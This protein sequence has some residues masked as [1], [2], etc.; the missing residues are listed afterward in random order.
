MASRTNSMSGDLE[1]PEPRANGYRADENTVCSSVL[2]ANSP[3]YVPINTRNPNYQVHAQALN[4]YPNGSYQQQYD[5][6]YQDQYHEHANQDTVTNGGSYGTYDPS[7]M[8]YVANMPPYYHYPSPALLQ[9]QYFH[10]PDLYAQQHPEGGAR[11]EGHAGLVDSSSTN[12][13]VG[14]ATTSTSTSL[15]LP[16][17]SASAAAPSPLLSTPPISS[18]SDTS[19]IHQ[20]PLPRYPHQ[21]MLNRTSFVPNNLLGPNN[22]H[23]E[24]PQVQTN[25]NPGANAMVHVNN[26]FVNLSLFNS[27]G[28][29]TGVAQASPLANPG[30]MMQ[31]PGMSLHHAVPMPGSNYPFGMSYVQP[32]HEPHYPSPGAH[33]RQPHGAKA[34]RDAALSATRAMTRGR[35]L[36]SHRGETGAQRLPR[37]SEGDRS[38]IGSGVDRNSI[39]EEMCDFNESDFSSNAPGNDRDVH[40]ARR[41][42]TDSQNINNAS[43]N[44]F[45]GAPIFMTP[46]IPYQPRNDGYVY[47]NML[48]FN[49]VAIAP[50]VP[51]GI[52]NVPQV[53]DTAR[54]SG[55]SSPC[56]TT[57]IAGVTAP[58]I[59]NVPSNYISENNMSRTQN[60]MPIPAHGTMLPNV[61]MT[62]HLDV[63]NTGTSASYTDHMTAFVT[64]PQSCVPSDHHDNAYTTVSSNSVNTGMIYQSNNSS[65][66]HN[67]SQEEVSVDNMTASSLASPVCSVNFTSATSDTLELSSNT[68]SYVVTTAGD[69]QNEA[70]PVYAAYVTSSHQSIHAP[71]M[72]ELAHEYANIEVDTSQAGNDAA[73]LIGGDFITAQTSE[74]PNGNSQIYEVTPSSPCNE[75]NDSEII[76]IFETSHEQSYSFSFSFGEFSPESITEELRKSQNQR[77]NFKLRSDHN[78]CAPFKNISITSS[79]PVFDTTSVMA[80]GSDSVLNFGEIPEKNLDRLAPMHSN[81][82]KQG[83]VTAEKSSGGITSPSLASGSKTSP[84]LE[85]SS[86]KSSEL[87]SSDKK[88]VSSP[89]AT[90]ISADASPCSAEVTSVVATAVMSEALSSES[91]PTVMHVHAGTAEKPPLPSANK[92]QTQKQEQQPRQKQPPQQQQNQP[93]QLEQPQQ[94]EQQRERIQQE[95]RLQQ[96]QQQQQVQEEDQQRTV[97]S[98]SSHLSSAANANEPAAPSA[99]GKSKNWEAT[100]KGNMSG[101]TVKTAV[102][103]PIM[104]NGALELEDEQT[105]SSRPA[106]AATCSAIVV[107][108]PASTAASEL[109]DNTVSLPP[110]VDDTAIKM[111]KTKIGDFLSEY[112]ADSS[113]VMLQPRGL[114]NKN[115][116][117]YSNTVLQSLTA[118][119]Q[120]VN[121][122]SEMQ[123]RVGSLITPHTMPIS[124]SIITYLNEF[125]PMNT[126]AVNLNVR[127]RKKA[128]QNVVNLPELQSGDP[129]EPSSV[130][131]MLLQKTGAQFQEGYQQDAEE[132]LSFLLN[133]SHDEFNEC[134]KLAA[135]EKEKLSGQKIPSAVVLP[136]GQADDNND[137]WVTMGPKNKAC[138]TRTTQFSHSPISEIFWG[139]S[140]A[141]IKKG[142]SPVT[143]NLEPFITLPL[144]IQDEAVTSVKEA[145]NQFV[146]KADVAGYTCTDTQEELA[147]S[148]HY[149]LEQLPQ[150]L[151][152]QLKR[153]VYS[154]DGGLQKVTKD[155]SLSIDLEIS[156]DLISPQKRKKLSGEQTKYKLVSVIYHDGKDANKGHYVCNVYHPGYHCWLHYDDSCVKPIVSAELQRFYAPRVPYILFYRRVDTFAEGTAPSAIQ[157]LP[158]RRR[159]NKDKRNSSSEKA[160][161]TERHEELGDKPAAE[162][163]QL[164]SAN[165][166][167][168]SSLDGKP[169]SVERKSIENAQSLSQLK[170]NNNKRQEKKQFKGKQGVSK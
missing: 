119:P 110:P 133:A 48:P 136:N 130:Q 4:G 117:C 143:N 44:V 94:Q 155:I 41:M 61:S 157:L 64:V 19:S 79:N 67:F 146:S 121:L 76:P 149:L 80:S 152:L 56:E 22:R 123:Q 158:N 81:E 35:G 132:M 73:S 58:L 93:H 57:G 129:F 138:I 18:M 109:L 32:Q 38:S 54:D 71:L 7:S 88:L 116:W 150:V 24:P 89:H 43:L 107:A 55:C 154:K 170:S 31:Q 72:E 142:N 125:R 5:R 156:K 104:R 51:M 99:W 105:P 166:S 12:S 97:V 128:G 115:Y 101:R 25:Q 102:I 42:I 9:H 144:D 147:V 27:P 131:K 122:Y 11:E 160:S 37:R 111:D 85:N 126:S 74:A 36:P 75:A 148:S 169:T 92:K 86:V 59:A 135:L 26:S 106:P 87:L 91:A 46:T 66:M 103:H 108:G 17:T 3:A 164:F 139:E 52:S 134:I 127:A 151:I 141:I 13:L 77:E 16:R 30:A 168:K 34:S 78:S 159:I 114:T 49:V 83:G 145:L 163:R 33:S 124:H 65:C 162:D 161:S 95:Q 140:R 68:A 2:N 1:V 20:H 137:D 47:S 45:E 15:P 23:H 8:Q 69:S 100:F 84:M 82:V 153:F 14:S 40:G 70:V 96:Q 165:N 10:R 21:P 53:D 50:G 62:Y 90:S 63:P 29:Y 120:F 39:N 60:I 113:N 167:R 98:E 112:K 118:V 28:S 6:Q